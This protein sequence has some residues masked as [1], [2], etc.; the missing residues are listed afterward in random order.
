MHAVTGMIGATPAGERVHIVP[1]SAGLWPAWCGGRVEPI[2]WCISTPWAGAGFK[3]AP[4]M[5][6]VTGMIGAT[7]AGE[8]VHIAPGSAGIL[9][10][11]TRRGR[12]ALTRRRLRARAAGPH[13]N[14]QIP[15]VCSVRLRRCRVRAAER[16]WH[17][18]PVPYRVRNWEFVPLTLLTPCTYYR[19]RKLRLPQPN[20]EVGR[21][22]RKPY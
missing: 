22:N 3:P 11:Q 8:R 15:L 17:P 10:S 9:P 12:D 7:P 21:I 16:T 5:H 6:A 2:V 19:L 14:A 4:T 13:M 18:L 1:G 20:D